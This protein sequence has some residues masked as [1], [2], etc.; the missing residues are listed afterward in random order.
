MKVTV[1]VFSALVLAVAIVLLVSQ[2]STND[3]SEHAHEP[4]DEKSS[5]G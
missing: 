1:L 2:Q 4:I 3:P 5:S